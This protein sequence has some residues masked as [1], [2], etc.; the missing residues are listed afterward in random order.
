ML[1]EFRS[2]I[3]LQPARMPMVNDFWLTRRTIS[4]RARRKNRSHC[5]DWFPF[6]SDSILLKW[7]WKTVLHAAKNFT[8]KNRFSFFLLHTSSAKTSLRIRV[9]KIYCSWKKCIFIK[10]SHKHEIP[11][12][13]AVFCF[14]FSISHTSVSFW[15]ANETD[16]IEVTLLLIKINPFLIRFECL[17]AK[18]MKEEN[19][20]IAQYNLKFKYMFSQHNPTAVFSRKTF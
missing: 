10:F 7:A 5:K 11:N 1:I 16:V 15:I 18:I 2:K 6:P 14:V 20:R 19:W 9:K 8:K 4:E 13:T 3:K 17:I 12:K